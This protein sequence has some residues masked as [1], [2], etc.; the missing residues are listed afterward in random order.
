MSEMRVGTRLGLGFGAVLVLM[1]CMALAVLMGLRYIERDT[2]DIVEDKFPKTDWSNDIRD[3]INDIAIRM[4]DTLM[5]Q[6]PARI[7]G[8][9][10]ALLKDWDRV[11]DRQ[12]KLEQSLKSQEAKKIFD[13]IRDTHV[14]YARLQDE[15][16]RLVKAHRRDEA[17]SLFQDRIDSLQV[18][19]RDLAVKMDQV[20]SAQ[21]RQQGQVID[22]AVQRLA[23]LILA[24]AGVALVL[25]ILIAVRIVRK[26]ACQLGGEPGYAVDVMRRIA[27]G[28]LS[29]DLRLHDG[30]TSSLL[31]SVNHMQAGLRGII[32]EI[33][34]LVEAA[35]LRGDFSARVSTQTKAGFGK[36][37]AE[38]LNKQSEVTETGLDDIQQVVTALAAGDLSQKMTGSYVGAFHQTKVNVNNTVD[39][40]VRI[41]GEIKSMVD[42]AA[43]RGD[44][45]VRLTLAD[46]RGFGRE[47]AELLNKQSAVTE[48]GLEDV[49]RVVTALANGD[50]SQ[51]MTQDYQGV[52]HHTKISVNHTVEAL[53]LVIGEIKAVVDAVANRGDFTA[54]LDLAG[55]A[56]YIKEVAELLNQLF[57]VSEAW[58]NDI[59]RLANALAQGDL[60]Q[61]IGQDYPGAF[62]EVKESMNTTLGNLTGIIGQVKEG[63]DAISMA[64]NEISTGNTNLSSRT[65]QQ[66][67]SLEETASSMEEL[68]ATVRNNADNALR[69]NRLAND[70][71]GKAEQGGEVVQQA[72]RAMDA[73]D[74]ASQRIGEIIGVIDEIAFQTNLLAL[75]ASVEAARAGEQG[76]GFA[77]VATEVRNLASRSAAAAKEIKVLIRDSGD[78]VKAGSGLVNRSGET[79]DEIKSAVRK[80]VDIVAEMAAASGE[81]S[82]GISQVNEAV[83]T[84]DEMTQQNASL[85]EQT[86]AASGSLSQKAR[87]M[88]ELMGFF[89][90]PG[91]TR[92]GAMGQGRRQ[93]L[94]ASRVTA[95]PTRPRPPATAGAPALGRNT[96][97]GLGN[98]R[99]AGETNKPV[100][101]S[102]DRGQSL[103]EWEEF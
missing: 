6:E 43:N 78:K 40:L 97:T 32:G 68:T 7:Q 50:L 23:T 96:F 37:L 30:D 56:G 83:T 22:E 27:G 29:R 45:S 15:F 100:R 93:A 5:H 92:P 53:T 69:A 99:P 65:E 48:A 98:F 51:E 67:A 18:A 36:D 20:V 77:V 94:S 8:E 66:A 44:F 101:V 52:F 82:I 54:K 61:T 1:C 21:L 41:I 59:R 81:Q 62:G 24:L 90:V 71:Q 9:V 17:N 87:E 11:T 16:L 79:L 19:Y 12:A 42:A 88:D 14:Q 91:G 60:T 103:E 25:G 39:A 74:A 64:A 28:D 3:A 80:L 84:M 10:D 58:L 57:Q 85:A 95:L 33:R 89:T 46:K 102:A 26:L 86:S 70:A 4:R 47:V 49:N 73:I 75:N 34:D 63:M 38:L 2:L 31:Y 13:Q 55:K 76:R 72:V 35:A